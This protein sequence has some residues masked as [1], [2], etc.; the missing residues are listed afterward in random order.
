MKRLIFASLIIFSWAGAG[1]AQPMEITMDAYLLKV[2]QS[3][4]FFRKE[5]LTVDVERQ[6][7]ERLTGE[8]DWVL[9]AAP[10]YTHI[11]PSRA[12][13]FNPRR[14][15]QM[16]VSLG[17]SRYFWGAGSTLSVDYGY[18]HT[19]LKVDDISIPL[20]T[21][22][23]A[24][25]NDGGVFQEN[26][27]TVTYRQPLIQNRGGFLS[28]LAHTLQGFNVDASEL[29]ARENQEDYLLR[30]GGMFIDWALL[31]EQRKI[32]MT[33]LALAEE[34]LGRTQEKRKHNLVDEV[35]MIRAKDAVIG[36]RQ[37]IRLLETALE[38]VEAELMALASLNP[39]LK[40]A[41]RF[42]L[43]APA[44]DILPLP[45]SLELLDQRSRLL[46]TLDV[47]LEQVAQSQQG[48]QEMEMPR[49]D[50]VL[51]AGVKGGDK[52]FGQAAAMD[53]P[54][55][56]AALVF[57]YPLGNR[58]ARAEI[59]RAALAREK[60]AEE[61]NNIRL[62]LQTS[63]KGVLARI[64]ALEQTLA[65][66]R[67]RIKTSEEKTAAELKRYEQGRTELT[68]V[69]LSRDA[70]EAARLAHAQDSASYQ[71]L[72]LAYRALMDALAPEMEEEPK[73]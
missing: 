55:A 24:M 4:P 56:M 62:E 70:E 9:S 59:A 69:I 2:R 7:Q 66:D 31:T 38:G 8:E 60:L 52:D 29:I 1:L 6:A 17:A 42:D 22:P 27:L 11:E 68:F 63:I 33:R 34:E 61:R 28:R 65:L 39:E 40:L 46:K 30:A 35:D 44:S 21:G 49:M 58:A 71:K 73:P 12:G 57:S 32:S 15:D 20:P 54:Q 14:I 64:Y 45:R 19:N 26:S 37:G 3:H 48:A 47:R 67:G 43:Y 25:P 36:A 72:A 16:G 10:S 41:P 50:A 18:T 13:G 53:K 51:Q 5:A 23:I